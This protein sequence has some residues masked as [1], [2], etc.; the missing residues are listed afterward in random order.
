LKICLPC[1][2]IS[3]LV[4]TGGL[5]DVTANLADYYI[6]SGHDCRVLTPLQGNIDTSA[7]EIEEV[8]G[9]QDLELQLGGRSFTY[10]ILRTQLPDKGTV[11]YLL[12]CAPL[13]ARGELYAGPDEHLRFILLSRA[14]IEMCQRMQFA[15][16]I[17]HCHDWHTAL[18][19]VYLKT[20]YAWD[21]LFVGSRSVL[22]I[23]N[24]GFQGAFG[25]GILYEMGLSGSPEMLD[26]DDLACD[27]VNF[28]KTGI[29]HADLLTTVSPTYAREILD[30][31]FGMGLEGLLQ[32]RRESLVG[33]LNGADYDEWN[34]ASDPL[35][36]ENYS[37]GRMEGKERNKQ[38][39]L[40]ELG[41][42]YQFDRPVIGMVTEL[43]Y[44]AGIE[45]IQQ[46]LPELLKSRP[47][48]LAVLGH[49]E[50]RHERFFAWLRTQ[51]PD[52]VSYT[53]DYDN[54]LAHRIVAGS[55]LFLMPSRYEPCGLHQMHS[56]RYGTVPI[57]R[58][59]GGLTDSV[60]HFDPVKGSGTGVVFHDFDANGLRWAM[61]TAL[62]LYANKHDWR[63]VV[64]NGMEKNYSWQE[65]GARYIKRFRS[66]L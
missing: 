11:V 28:L 40:E 59:T 1:A 5:A 42:A 29:M 66:L 53:R 26:Q 65:Q 27:R 38:A 54:A 25:G 36:S 14:A 6:R 24:I 58:A 17:F 45:L 32:G 44:Q 19:P 64:F 18:L 61:K 13:Y 35:I 10:S 60:Q 34:P 63:H 57:V 9:L 37:P 55:D 8:A 30:A 7:L 48:S 23:H 47:L 33:I 39:L 16:D 43:T 12:S 3:P 22:T 46:V 50:A 56:L 21:Q 4:E 49:G 31:E 52:R 62:D 2:E 15:P 20:R 51:F 41:L